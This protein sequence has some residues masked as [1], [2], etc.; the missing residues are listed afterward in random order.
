MIT[1]TSTS[2]K[3][4]GKT[5]SYSG[6]RR[7]QPRINMTSIPFGHDGKKTAKYNAQKKQCKYYISQN[8]EKFCFHG[9]KATIFLPFSDTDDTKLL[10]LNTNNA[11]DTDKYKKQLRITSASF[12]SENNQ[13][14]S[15]VRIS[16]LQ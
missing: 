1:T 12:A 9:Y 3:E 11:D 4:K 10:F 7:R 2:S 5:R 16:S 8:R 15:Q 6:Q 13:N 14:K